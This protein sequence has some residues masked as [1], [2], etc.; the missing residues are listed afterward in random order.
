MTI[1]DHELSEE[2]RGFIRR[3][4]TM[5]IMANLTLEQIATQA[6]VQGMVDAVDVITRR[7]ANL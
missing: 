5:A 4:A 7:E 1:Y 3:R 6:Y 2:V